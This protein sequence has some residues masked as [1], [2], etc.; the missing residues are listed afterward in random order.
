MAL[1]VRQKNTDITRWDPFRD[2]AELDARMNRIFESAMGTR[3]SAMWTPPVDVEETDTSYVV[4]AELPGVQKDDISI[5]LTNNV[6]SIH[7]EAKERERVG[8]LRHKTRRTGEFD[9]RMT[10]PSDVD[11]DNVSATLDDGVLRVEVAKTEA[12][13]PKQITIS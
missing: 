9:Y 7:G 10:M 5:E 1:P 8:I 11:A 6:L 3:R 13:Q 4:E 2:L 12:A